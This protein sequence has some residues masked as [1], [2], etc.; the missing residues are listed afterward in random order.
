MLELLEDFED[1]LK[2][3]SDSGY[4]GP[5]HLIGAFAPFKRPVIELMD[6]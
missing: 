6:E 5:S 1:L 3:Y 2:R 4:Y